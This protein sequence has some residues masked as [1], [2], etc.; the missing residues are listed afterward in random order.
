M[1]EKDKEKDKEESSRRTRKPRKYERM[2][3]DILPKGETGI[4]IIRSGVEKRLDDIG[5]EPEV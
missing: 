1:T 5:D 3:G 4:V 2:S